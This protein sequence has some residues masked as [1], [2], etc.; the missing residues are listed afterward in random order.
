VAIHPKITVMGQYLPITGMFA[1]RAVKGVGYGNALKP[2]SY[3]FSTG[4]PTTANSRRI[5]NIGTNQSN[6]PRASVAY[7]ANQWEFTPGRQSTFF[8]NTPPV[9]AGTITDPSDNTGG[10]SYSNIIVFL[11]VLIAAALFFRK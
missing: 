5:L 7:G 2:G 6:D 9:S 11:A 10:L 3:P 8:P 1:F 4:Y